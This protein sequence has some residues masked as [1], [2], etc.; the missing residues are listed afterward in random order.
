MVLTGPSM[1]NYHLNIILILPKVYLDKICVKKQ[2][3]IKC[4]F[5]ARQWSKLINVSFLSK[6]IC[7]NF[8]SIPSGNNWDKIRIIRH[9]QAWYQ[10]SF[11]CQPLE[12]QHFDQLI[13]QTRWS[14]RIYLDRDKNQDEIKIRDM[15][16]TD[17]KCHFI[18]SQWSEGIL[19]NVSG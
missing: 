4:H 9:G 2:M 11:H 5:I 1:S 18:A 12:Q 16:R 15:D 8:I 10:M 14:S 17:V 19:I 6:T 7:P 3:I 13:S